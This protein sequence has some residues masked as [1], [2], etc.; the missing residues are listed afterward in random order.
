MPILRHFVV[1]YLQD[2]SPVDKSVSLAPF[3]KNNV[4]THPPH[5]SLGGMGRVFLD[6]STVLILTSLALS[7]PPQSPA[8]AHQISP[9]STAR[10]SA[11]WRTWQSDAHEGCSEV[12]RNPCA[13]ALGDEPL[14]GGVEDGAVDVRLKTA[15]EYADRL[16][17]DQS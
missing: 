4:P 1:K 17:H 12:L 13:L 8:S 6:T 10:R 5:T 2:R 15:E 9:P 7:P 11:Y 3:I 16:P 14:A